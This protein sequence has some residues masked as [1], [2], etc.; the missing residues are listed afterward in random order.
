MKI[1]LTLIL[2]DMLSNEERDW[3]ELLEYKNYEL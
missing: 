3:N 1:T 2:E